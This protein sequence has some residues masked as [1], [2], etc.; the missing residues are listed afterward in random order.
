MTNRRPFMPLYIAD[1]DGDTRHLTAEEDGVYG[2]LLRAMWTA[3][4]QL[5]NSDERL[6]QIS[7]ISLWRWRKMAA[8][9]MA[10]FIVVD[11][12]IEQKRMRRELDRIARVS[13]VRQQAGKQGGRPNAAVE[14]SERT[15]SVRSDQNSEKPLKNG[16]DENQLLS[17]PRG[18]GRVVRDRDL[19]LQTSDLFEDPKEGSSHPEPPVGA[20]GLSDRQLLNEFEFRFWK[21]YPER[22]SK[23][24]AKKAWMKARRSAGADE[25]LAGVARYI[26]SKP[27]DRQWQYPA[28]WLNAEG[29]LD[30][31]ATMPL[32]TA[33]APPVAYGGQPPDDDEYSE[34]NMLKI[35]AKLEAKFNAKRK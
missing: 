23:G 35:A 32:A 34:A 16:H 25:I 1:Y 29:W 9:I 13:K 31:P 10:F 19:R 11:D 33:R 28:T 14:N 6:A 8:T 20:P 21:A 4:G 7:R 5:P 18:R 2:R 17:N 26:A 27:A 12:H 3:G 30:E 22:K 15:A 24:Q